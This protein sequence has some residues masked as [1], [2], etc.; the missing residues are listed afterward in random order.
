MG[1]RN[2]DLRVVELAQ[3][4][5]SVQGPSEFSYGSFD[6]GF[7]RLVKRWSQFG[8]GNVTETEK[9]CGEC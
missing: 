7:I 2:P 1:L 5:D 6:V 3:R 4:A 9:N 8:K